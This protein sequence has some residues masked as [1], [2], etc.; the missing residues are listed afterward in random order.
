MTLHMKYAKMG[1]TTK[2]ANEVLAGMI[3]HRIDLEGLVAKK[4]ATLL[5]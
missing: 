5:P 4:Q 3:K 1:K 2:L